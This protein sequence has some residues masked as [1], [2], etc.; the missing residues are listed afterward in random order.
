MGEVE[1][2]G[3]PYGQQAKSGRRGETKATETVALHLAVFVNLRDENE[4]KML[5]SPLISFVKSC[6]KNGDILAIYH[7]VR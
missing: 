1:T 4:I 7:E 3:M 5:K 6:C 2:C